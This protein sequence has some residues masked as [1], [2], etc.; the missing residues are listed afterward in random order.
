MSR[1][2][3]FCTVLGIVVYFFVDLFDLSQLLFPFLELGLE[4][5]LGILGIDVLRVGG[6][7]FF[8]ATT[9]VATSPFFFFLITFGIAFGTWSHVKIDA[10]FMRSPAGMLEAF[11]KTAICGLICLLLGWALSLMSLY[12]VLDLFIA[13]YFFVCG[14]IPG[15]VVGV[16]LAFFPGIKKSSA[17]ADFAG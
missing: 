5:S 10:D 15:R 3:L 6:E 8:A 13:S 9:S 14:V 16:I 4:A 2:T 17:G 7:S 11:V 1:D 12:A